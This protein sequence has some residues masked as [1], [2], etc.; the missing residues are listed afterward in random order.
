MGPRKSA[1]RRVPAVGDANL[2]DAFAKHLSREV[3]NRH[4]AEC[5]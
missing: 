4:V 3:L 2:V 1:P 5:R